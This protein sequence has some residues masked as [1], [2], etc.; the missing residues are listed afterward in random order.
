MSI[1]SDTWIKSMAQEQ[2]MIEPFLDTQVRA[3][4]IS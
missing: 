2:K 4:V 3:G 1:Q